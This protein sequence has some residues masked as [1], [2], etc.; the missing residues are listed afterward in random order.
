MRAGK[1]ARS[2]YSLTLND[3]YR[4]GNLRTQL[5]EYH[6]RLAKMTDFSG[7]EMPLW[8]MGIQMECLAVRNHAGIFDVSHMGRAFIKGPDS[9]A[10][11]NYLTPND[12]SKLKP[13]R[14]HYTVLCNERGG[15][16]DD[17][18]LLRVD[19]NL[20]LLVFNAGNRAK[21]LVWIEAHR[22]GFNV[23]VQHVSDEVAMIAIQGPKARG[24]VEAAC[25]GDVSSVGRFGC[26]YLNFNGVNCIASG[27]GYTGEDGLEIFVPNATLENP[28]NAMK[29]WDTL[30]S[31]GE[32]DS[33]TPCGLGARDV[34]RLEAGM[35]LYGNEL[36]ESITPF[37][38]S[39]GFVVKLDKEAD[40]I[41]RKALEEQKTHGVPRIRVGVKLLEGGVPRKGN[42]I[43]HNGEV[44]GEVTSGTFS[45]ILKCGIA[46]GYVK[47][48]Y[49]EPGIKVKL[50]IR[51]R[52]VNGEVSPLP[53]YDTSMYGWRR[54]RTNNK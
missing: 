25:E 12:V 41:G 5:Y 14:A 21:D 42:S 10:F 8:Y 6:K 44:V 20:F 33:L 1:R 17:V 7:F 2:P 51:E 24:V 29:V 47:P 37:E 30:L 27:T 39:I 49:R 36:N 18:M 19:R 53:F 50:K 40:F 32:G 3:F 46:M 52:Y 34:L 13:G 16:V 22:K 23:D 43:L 31:V 4:S 15:V 9:E 54:T 11:L 35:C 28:G 26:G 48:E 38:A 45:P